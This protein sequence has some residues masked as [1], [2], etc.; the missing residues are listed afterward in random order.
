M[1]FFCQPSPS[2]GFHPTPSPLDYTSPLTP[3]GGITP[4]PLGSYGT[5]GS[6]GSMLDHGM[7]VEWQSVDIAVRVKESHDESS[8]RGK[9][10]VIRSITVSDTFRKRFSH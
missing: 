10:G 5:P 8:T 2:S 1:A 6:V 9:I 3:G 7:S 4:S